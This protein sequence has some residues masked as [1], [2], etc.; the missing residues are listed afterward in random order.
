MLFEI[1]LTM[2]IK[3]RFVNLSWCIEVLSHVLILLIAENDRS[4]VAE[5]TGMDNATCNK[6]YKL[7]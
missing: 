6:E 1:S 3:E 4:H 5:L 7:G 2:C